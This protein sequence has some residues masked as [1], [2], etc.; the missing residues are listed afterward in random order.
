MK[1]KVEGYV[2]YLGRPRKDGYRSVER[3]RLTRW[4]KLLHALRRA[5]LRSKMIDKRL[6]VT[7]DDP[8]QLLL[9]FSG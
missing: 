2:L 5:K 3:A 7:T 1:L 8:D 9:P 6:V 4:R